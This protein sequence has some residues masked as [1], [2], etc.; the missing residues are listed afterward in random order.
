M[1]TITA[2]VVRKPPME[3]NVTYFFS[4]LKART[5]YTFPEAFRKVLKMDSLRI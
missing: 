5:M 2:A 4:L 3:F 1:K